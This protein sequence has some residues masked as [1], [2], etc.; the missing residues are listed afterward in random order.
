MKRLALATWPY[1]AALLAGGAFYILG[2]FLEGDVGA[3]F[4]GIAGSFIAIPILYLIYERSRQYSRR[5][6]SRELLDYAK[7]QIDRDLFFGLRYLMKATW[8]YER[9]DL[10]LGG[11]AAFLDQGR[12]EIAETLRSVRYLGFQVL[13]NWE[14]GQR[15]LETVLENPLVVGTLSEDQCIA[16]IGILRDVRSLQSLSRE[17]DVLFQPTGDRAEGY[18]VQSG[19][20]INPANAGYPDRYLLLRG[21]GNGKSRVVDFADFPGHRAEMLL[22][23]YTIRE[24]VLSPYAEAI[25]GFLSSVSCWIELTGGEFLID[26]QTLRVATMPRQEPRRGTRSE[27]PREPA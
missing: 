14:H 15:A 25:A 12:D 6:L 4:H 3:L 26:P 16:V 27:F 10:T 20:D 8:P 9:Q 2:S 22:D 21:I 17:A 18:H 23:L 1:I 13:R 19:A 5:R 11:V 7:F 24:S